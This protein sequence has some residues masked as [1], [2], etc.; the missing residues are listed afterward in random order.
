MLLSIRFVWLPRHFS[1]IQVIRLLQVLLVLVIG[2]VRQ[3]FLKIV[4]FV[5][6]REYF[7]RFAS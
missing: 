6:K 2:N 1:L 5:G 3:K 7:W 4:N